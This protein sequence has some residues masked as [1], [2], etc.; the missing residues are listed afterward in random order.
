MISTVIIPAEVLAEAQAEAKA[1]V[2][3]LSA[4][5]KPTSEGQFAVFVVES[6]GE[7]QVARLRPVEVGEVRGNM[8]AVSKGLTKGEQVVTTGASLLVDGET[9]RIIP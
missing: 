8:V 3:P 2:V 6:S 5:V 7:K 9:V 4:I 1:L